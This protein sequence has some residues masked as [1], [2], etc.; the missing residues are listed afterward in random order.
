M[1]PFRLEFHESGGPH[2][3]KVSGQLFAGLAKTD[4]LCDNTVI[5]YEPPYGLESRQ[6]AVEVDFLVVAVPAVAEGVIAA[7]LA[8]FAI[9]DPKWGRRF[10]SALNL[11]AVVK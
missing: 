6:E 4:K 7:A 10:L 11:P 8:I 5:C 2:C 9:R 1:V 3:L